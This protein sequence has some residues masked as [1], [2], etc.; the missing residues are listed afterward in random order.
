MCFSLG[1][2]P[3]SASTPIFNG[4]FDVGPEWVDLP[5]TQPV[6]AIW[7]EQTVLVDVKTHFNPSIFPLDLRLDDGSLA[8]PEI[9]ATSDTGLQ[10]LLPLKW[11]RN[12]NIAAFE[13]GHIPKGT[14][15]V[16]VQIRCSVPI[17]ISKVTWISYVPEDTKTG[18]P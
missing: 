14:R 1:C 3:R 12:S 13:N 17:V 5:L 18:N 16:R 2:R 7:Q 4:V 11:F 8:V 10:E 6:I 9:K 15:F